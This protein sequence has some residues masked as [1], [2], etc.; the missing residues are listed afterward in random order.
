[1]TSAIPG[2]KPTRLGINLQS[3][4][5]A[6]TM[7]FAFL[8]TLAKIHMEL[9]RPRFTQLGSVISDPS[10]EFIVGPV[11]GFPH[12]GPFASADRYWQF[13]SFFLLQ[14]GIIDAGDDQ[15]MKLQSMLVVSI[16]RETMRSRADPRHEEGPFLLKHPYLCE[17]NFLVDAAG[18]IIGVIDWHDTRTAPIELCAIPCVGLIKSR[19]DGTPPSEIQTQYGELLAAAESSMG[20]PPLPSGKTFAELYASEA[21]YVACVVGYALKSVGCDYQSDPAK[22]LGLIAGPETDMEGAFAAFTE[23]SQAQFGMDFQ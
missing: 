9:A 12:A 7:I 22:D 4:S 20:L 8:E 3:P 2:M 19:P 6:P 14:S 18:R 21:A 23:E 16:W 10:G 5:A 1:M 15:S 17:D 13:E 11:S